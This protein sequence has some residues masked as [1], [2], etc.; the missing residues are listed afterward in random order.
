MSKKHALFIASYKNDFKWLVHCL[1]SIYRYASGFEAPVVCVE[2]HELEE[3]EQIMS[4][5]CPGGRVVVKNGRV[6][7]GPM[8]GQLAMMV[9]DLICPE[10]DVL[11]FVGSDC[12]FTRPFSPDDF[13][14]DGVPVVLMTPYEEIHKVAP[15]PFCWLVGVRRI[16][17]LD[18]PF[19]FM[20]RLPSVFPREIFPAMRACIADKHGM[21]FEEF[22]Y[23]GDIHHKDTSEANLLGAFAYEFMRDTCLF[24]DTTK[25][26]YEEW[27]QSPLGQLWSWGGL[28]YRADACFE[29]TF[30]GER[31]RATGLRPR[32][33]IAEILY[34]GDESR[35][36][37]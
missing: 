3:A 10:A 22:I 32:Q 5:S 12:V 9:S 2:Q 28:D 8:R 23:K 33:I 37:G 19:E 14:K 31:K 4:E 29:Y 18:T 36:K 25:P 15:N 7:Q 16:L 17:G 21:P 26:E 1:T 24:I 35:V 6:N 34:D 13:C 20:R 27:N 11:Y 30:R